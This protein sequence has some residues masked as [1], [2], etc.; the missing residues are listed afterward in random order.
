[1]REILRLNNY[2]RLS[3]GG[4]GWQDLMIEAIS[5]YI[6]NFDGVKFQ[7]VSWSFLFGESL[8]KRSCK[9]NFEYFNGKIRPYGE[10]FSSEKKLSISITH[11]F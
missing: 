6:N 7:N 4:A 1:M 5:L 10:R 11:L 9:V 3:S 8:Q 2:P